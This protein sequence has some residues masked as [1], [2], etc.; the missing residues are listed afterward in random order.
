LAKHV[1]F[2]K[3]VLN[4]KLEAY[5]SLLEDFGVHQKP[6]ENILEIVLTGDLGL[7]LMRLR[8]QFRLL[9]RFSMQFTKITTELSLRFIGGLTKLLM[10]LGANGCATQ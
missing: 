8:K 3:Y 5:L 7:V 4:I 9:M 1:K 2:R 10:P 6:K